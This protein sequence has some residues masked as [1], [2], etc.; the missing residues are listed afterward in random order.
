[1]LTAID[2]L[3]TART[4]VTLRNGP[5]PLNEIVGTVES[6][7]I[8]V[9]D[10]REQNGGWLRVQIS[11]GGHGWGERTAFT[12]ADTFN[13]DDLQIELNFPTPIPTSTH[14]PTST[15]T[16]S[17]TPAPTNTRPAPTATGTATATV[18]VQIDVQP[19]AITPAS[20]SDDLPK[21]PPGTG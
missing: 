3:C 1:M 14:T 6:G 10:A 19:L 15:P 2:P 16:P 4:E 8:V 17:R 18:F 7:Q 9:V 5:T 21:T 11:G 20:E 12:C 13:V